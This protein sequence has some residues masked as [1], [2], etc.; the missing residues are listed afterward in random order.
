MSPGWYH[1]GLVWSEQAKGRTSEEEPRATLAIVLCE[2]KR[3]NKLKCPESAGETRRVERNHPLECLRPGS[4]QEENH[5]TWRPMEL[6][7]LTYISTSISCLF[8]N[9]LTIPGRGNQAF[10]V[11]NCSPILLVQGIG[12]CYNA[13]ATGQEQSPL[14]TV[15]RAAV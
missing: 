4:T 12:L 6:L 3:N 9:E 14:G 10:V 15:R 8:Q 2:E 5:S 1:S 13:P 7:L 11:R